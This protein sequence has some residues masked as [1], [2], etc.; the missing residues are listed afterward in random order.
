MSSFEDIYHRV[1]VSNG[2][3]TVYD[4]LVY[5]MTN[6]RKNVSNLLFPFLQVIPDT[7]FQKWYLLIQGEQDPPLSD[8][9]TITNSVVHI[10]LTHLHIRRV[11]DLILIKCI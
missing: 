11:I 2:A 1:L 10:S 7:I 8:I 3:E 5:I 4:R 9:I 6:Q